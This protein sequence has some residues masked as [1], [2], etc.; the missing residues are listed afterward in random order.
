MAG[1]RLV[2]RRLI[3]VI[4]QA[5]ATVLRVLPEN[6]IDPSPLSPLIAH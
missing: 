5:A 6:F 3:I 1:A 4:K 2:P